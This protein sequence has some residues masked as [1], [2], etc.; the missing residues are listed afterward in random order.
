MSKLGGMTLEDVRKQFIRNVKRHKELNTEFKIDPIRYNTNE[1]L[2]KNIVP[3]LPYKLKSSNSTELHLK[4]RL[5][6]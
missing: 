2:L 1:E 6:L 4:V 3:Q 5:F